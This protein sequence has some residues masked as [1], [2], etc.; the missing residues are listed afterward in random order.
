MPKT[1]SHASKN[2]STAAELTR[3]ILLN[4]LNNNNNNN[5]YYYYYYYYYYSVSYIS[6][7]RMLRS[8]PHLPSSCKQTHFGALKL[9]VTTPTAENLDSNR[10][11]P[12]NYN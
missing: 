6:G 7:N 9:P 1:Q 12:S 5:Y 3:P 10:I 2:L 8:Q 4:G 11:S